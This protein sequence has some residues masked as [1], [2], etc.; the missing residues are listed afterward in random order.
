MQRDGPVVEA[1]RSGLALRAI[2]GSK[3]PFLSRGTARSTVPTSV[4]SVLAMLPL[5]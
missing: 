3:L 4:S 2:F 5:R 1:A